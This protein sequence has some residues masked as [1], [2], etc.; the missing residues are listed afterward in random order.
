MISNNLFELQKILSNNGLLISFSGRFSQSIIEELGEAVKKYLETEDR[1]KNDVYNVF[2]IFIEQTQNIKNYCEIKKESPHY[3]RIANSCMV[4]I[5]KTETGNYIC[6]GNIVEQ[7]DAVVLTGIIDELIPLDK[8][9]LKKLYKEKL[10]Q[11]ISPDSLG[12][13]IGLVD[14]ARKASLPL[15]YS[16]TT[17]DDNFLFFT[18]KAVV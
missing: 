8:V 1:P 16:I 10:R 12:A 15:E 18:L 13:G 2:S 11:D 7:K 3:E 17:I 14:I 5:G 6:S 9:A 4:T